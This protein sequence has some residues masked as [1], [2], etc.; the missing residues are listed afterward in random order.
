MNLEKKLENVSNLARLILK[1]GFLILY[2]LLAVLRFLKLQK[3]H[4]E[5]EIKKTN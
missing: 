1:T 2:L 5:K 3:I 4:L